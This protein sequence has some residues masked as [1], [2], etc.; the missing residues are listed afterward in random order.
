MLCVSLSPLYSRWCVSIL[1]AIV[2]H[3]GIE[4][5]VVASAYL[6]SALDRKLVTALMVFFAAI[7]PLGIGLGI[8]VSKTE[9]VKVSSVLSVCFRKCEGGSS[10]C[11]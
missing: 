1:L 5:F 6:R 11:C 2:V 4:S 8:L 10:V 9:S 3:K 7:S